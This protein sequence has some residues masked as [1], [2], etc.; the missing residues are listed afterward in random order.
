MPVSKRK[1]KTRKTT[2]RTVVD[3]LTRNEP[4][5]SEFKPYEFGNGTVKKKQRGGI[6]DER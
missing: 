5:E 6:Y 2:L 1:P 3:A 4:P